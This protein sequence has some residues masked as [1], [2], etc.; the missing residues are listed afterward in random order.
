MNLAS[1]SQIGDPLPP[2]GKKIVPEDKP[3]ADAQWLP[4]PHNPNVLKNNQTGE[5]K[6]RDMADG[7]PVKKTVP[8]QA[9]NAP[10]PQKENGYTYWQYAGFVNA[11][12][13]VKG[14][15]AEWW[16]LQT[17]TW[18]KSLRPWKSSNF[19]PRSLESLT[20]EQLA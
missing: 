13:R 3:Q 11:P 4:L 8:W 14:T 17:G 19:T 12:Y 1:L 5:M 2:L 16:Q 18:Q 20:P 10:Q 9:D 6:T 7:A 15:S